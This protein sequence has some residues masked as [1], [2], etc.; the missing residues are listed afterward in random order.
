MASRKL[1]SQQLEE[2]GSVSDTPLEQHE[3]EKI[4]RDHSKTISTT[5]ELVSFIDIKFKNLDT[6]IKDNEVKLTKQINDLRDSVNSSCQFAIQTATEALNLSKETRTIVDDLK[7]EIEQLKH[8]I[9]K[10]NKVNHDQS[11]AIARNELYSRKRNLIFSSFDVLIDDCNVVVKRV[12]KTLCKENLK[13]ESAHYLGDKKQFIV[14]FFSLHDRELVWSERR[15][16]AGSRFFM[17]EDL[18]AMIK[19]EHDELFMIAKSAKKIPKFTGK[20]HL[21]A[22]KLSLDGTIYSGSNINDLPDEV[23][24]TYLSQRVSNEVV[25]FGGR[26]SKYNPLSNFFQANFFHN[27]TKYTTSEQAFQHSKALHF[28]DFDRA[29]RILNESDCMAQKRLGKHVIDFDSATWNSVRLN[30][31]KNILSSKFSQNPRLKKFLCDTG[32]RKI[33]EASLRDATY[34]IGFSISHHDVLN[35]DKWEG[36][37]ELG[38]I[39]MNIRESYK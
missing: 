6:T 22:N 17:N 15:K 32:S 21:Q 30:I 5:D 33:G 35:S 8:S 7:L 2:T 19:Q 14:R 27:K 31:L 29:Q 13:Y 25:C 3:T 12:L 10:I 24:P 37:N 20:V 34:G 23:H 26:L 11:Y 9:L 16:M 38:N 4:S 36:D 18:P 28:H 1:R 39:L